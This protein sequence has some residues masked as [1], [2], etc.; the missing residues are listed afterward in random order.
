MTPRRICLAVVMLPLLVGLAAIVIVP[1]RGNSLQN[2]S[3][4]DTEQIV[5]AGHL[6]CA[7]A[8]E[9]RCSVPGLSTVVSVIPDG[10][11]ARK[12]D[13]LIQLDN[14]VPSKQKSLAAAEL[15]Q[16]EARMNSSA[17]QID[18]IKQQLQ[19]ESQLGQLRLKLAELTLLNVTA[20]DGELAT[21]S[22]ALQR[23]IQYEESVRDANTD[24]LAVNA[25]RRNLENARDQLRLLEN[26][27]KPLRQAT[28]ELELTLVKAKTLQTENSL[29][30]E[31]TNANAQRNAYAQAAAAAKQ[32][33][34][35][36]EKDLQACSIHA[37]ADGLVLHATTNAGRSVSRPLAKGSR[38]RE[39]QLLLTMPDLSQLQ[40]RAHV[41]E[42]RIADVQVG[43]QAMLEFDALPDRR[44]K[45]TVAFMAPTARRSSQPNPQ[46]NVFEVIIKPDT[47]S[48][49]LKIGMTCLVEIDVKHA[50]NGKKK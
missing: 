3:P 35:Q 24:P 34:Q 43:Q 23:T 44:L 47:N 37:P 6:E 32:R 10:T 20:P 41:H 49:P 46:V 26:H 19:I 16:A 27:L 8:V 17:M 5:E 15:Q 13:L 39:R 7:S 38:V 33:L 9:L 12:G 21:Q 29:R 4:E 31:L 50:E 30:A 28:A 11:V 36:A 2:Q 48:L 14:S 45:G 25:A 1:A 18:S 40:V 42:S 22:A